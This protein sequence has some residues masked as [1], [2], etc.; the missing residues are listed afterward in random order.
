MIQFCRFIYSLK[1]RI[2]L[3][4]YLRNFM[5]VYCYF[6]LMIIF[7]FPTNNRQF[8]ALNRWTLKRWIDV[9][10]APQQFFDMASSRSLSELHITKLR[11]SFFSHFFILTLTYLYHMYVK[12]SNINVFLIFATAFYYVF[13][14]QGCIKYFWLYK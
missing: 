3:N 10:N 13:F 5:L 1:I 9:F 14:Y 11:N 2:F 6:H 7:K 12:N 4:T 8:S